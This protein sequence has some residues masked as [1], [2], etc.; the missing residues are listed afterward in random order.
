MSKTCSGGSFCFLQIFHESK[1][2]SWKMKGNVWLPLKFLKNEPIET[3]HHNQEIIAEN[4]RSFVLNV[5]CCF[6]LCFVVN[7]ASNGA[8]FLSRRLCALGFCYCVEIN[9]FP[10][11]SIHFPH[12]SIYF[13]HTTNFRNL[14]IFL[15]ELASEVKNTL[16]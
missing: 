16:Q 4:A 15:R 2:H 8:N 6:L 1:R 7:I 11:T 5:F 12:T 14:R 9:Y 3:F 10:H 13:P